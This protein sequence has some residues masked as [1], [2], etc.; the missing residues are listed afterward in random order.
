VMYMR[1]THWLV[2]AMLA[3]SAVLLS[4]CCCGRLIGR[5]AGVTIPTPGGAVTVSEGGKSTTITTPEGT[6]TTEQKDDKVTVKGDKGETMTFGQSID[7][8]V[9][10]KLDMPVYPKAEGQGSMDMSGSVMATYTTKEPFDDVASW[11]EK[12]LG[13]GWDKSTMSSGESKLTS[14]S[15]KDTE[16]KAG[17]TISADK[18]AVTIILTRDLGTK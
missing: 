9:I 15:S 1:G 3:S 14:F 5:K 2:A 13:S 11:Y 12:E 6:V 10:K 4:S 17:V 7:D 8:A 16:K 18:D